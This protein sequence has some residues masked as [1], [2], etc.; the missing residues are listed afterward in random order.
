MRV[1][2]IGQ[3]IHKGRLEDVPLKSNLRN[4][5]VVI[6]QDHYIRKYII[7]LYIFR[8]NQNKE[9]ACCNTSGFYTSQWLNHFWTQKT[10]ENVIRAIYIDEIEDTIEKV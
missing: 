7:D 10:I 8:G 1:V 2:I 6:K 9:R 5:S 3:E 4:T